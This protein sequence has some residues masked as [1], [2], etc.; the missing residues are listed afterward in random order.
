MK[1][2]STTVKTVLVVDDDE[3][4]I[5]LLEMMLE[6][7]EVKAVSVSSG[8]EAVDLIIKNQQD[9]FSI[10]VDL[11]M[12][13]MNGVDTF[14]ALRE[15]GAK[16][17]IYLATGFGVISEG[18]LKGAQFDGILQKPYNLTT[19]KQLLDLDSAV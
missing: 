1:S 18:E 12:P 17:P 19:L 11:S 4:I 8:A 15:A 9:F 5:R 6:R 2:F 16:V 7:L 10:I 3:M 14:F 13:R